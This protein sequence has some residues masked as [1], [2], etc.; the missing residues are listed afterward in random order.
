MNVDANA[1]ILAV[2]AAVPGTIVAIASYRS[3]GK[4]KREVTRRVQEVG[5]VAHDNATKIAKLNA[6][7][8]QFQHTVAV[9]TA[10]FRAAQLRQAKRD[11][12]F[13]ELDP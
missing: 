8:K 4:T 12:G 10:E 13:A 2:I 3:S 11:S 6:E 5:A 1:I 9:T 7:A